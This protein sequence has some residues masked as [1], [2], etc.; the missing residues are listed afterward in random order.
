MKIAL[1]SPYDFACP[2]GVVAHISQL[3]EQFTRMGHDVKVIGP[4]SDPD[5]STVHRDLIAIG[6]PIPVRSGGSVARITLS[7]FLGAAMRRILAEERFDV[8]HLHEPLGSTLPLTALVVSHAVNVGTFHACHRE[9]RGYQVARPFAAWWFRRLDG[10][11][12]VSKPAMRFVGKHLPGDYEIIPNGI[13]VGHFSAEV[14][15]LDGFDDGKLNILF[16]GRLEKRKGLRYL[17]AAYARVKRVLPESRLVVVGSGDRQPY[18][19]LAKRLGLQ[20]VVFVGH[21]RYADLPRYYRAADVFCAP[22]TGEESFGIVLLEAMAASRA[23]VASANEGYAGVLS[24][25]EEGLLVPPQDERATADALVTVLS[26]ESLRR[27]MGE[28]GRATADEYS[29][30]NVARRVLDYYERLLEQRSVARAV[31][32]G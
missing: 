8:V 27:R 18:V 9:P 25:G 5:P 3:H 29:W 2:G 11:I 10:K 28:R 30:A 20:D 32:M 13:D 15:P 6:R 19:R 17:L 12:A 23:I 21:V 22:A 14:P 24:D 31:R 4:C 1:I 16:V 7:P 26:D